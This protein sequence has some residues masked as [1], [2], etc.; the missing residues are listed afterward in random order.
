[1]SKLVLIP[2]S[3]EHSVLEPL[4]APTLDPDDD[5]IELCGFGVIAAAART[6]Q[7]LAHYRPD[8][9]FLVGIAGSI[10]N[11]LEIG[12][13]SAFSEVACYGVGAG[14]GLDHKTPNDMGWTQWPGVHD[15]IQLG[16]TKGPKRLLTVAA[17]SEGH[18]DV[19][20][21]VDRFPGAIAEDMEGFAVAMACQIADVPLTIVRG[22]SNAA[23]DRNVNNWKIEDALNAAGERLLRIL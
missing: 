20:L 7:L 18:G 15:V 14:T 4:L 9:V 22:I 21:R 1:M 23:G 19:Q 6:S 16:T 2:T 11:T 8:S 12:Q 13:A 3:V 10:G 5:A 17:A